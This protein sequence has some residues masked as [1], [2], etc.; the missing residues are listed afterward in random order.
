MPR[1]FH[2]N[3][4]RGATCL[5]PLVVSLVC[6]LSAGSSGAIASASQGTGALPPAT[7][8]ETVNSHAGAAVHPA[9]AV[10]ITFADIAPI[11]FDRCGM[12]HHPGGAAPF[13]LLTYPSARQRATQI[14]A[15][16]KS[17]FMPPW[18]SE[19][20]YGEFIG[21]RPLSDEEID[22][23]QRWAADGAPEGLSQHLPQP[24]W[25]DGWQLGQPDL[26][27]TLSQPYMLQADGTDVS[28]V[29]VLPIP[30]AT[31]RYVRGLEFRPGN[32]KVVHHANIRIDRTPASRQLDDE[33]PAPG[34]D[35]PILRSAV[36]PDGH[37]L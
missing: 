32:P 31:T 14:A 7:T 27:V 10:S 19:P 3:W 37:F 34:Y 16:T 35:G 23:I 9:P 17:R 13:S 15:M 5:R 33:D 12:C 36:Y 20:G 18:K 8:I 22:L 1:V 11:I 4:R 25:T 2:L 6:A 28:R 26:I 30:G 21:Q 29:F 24:H